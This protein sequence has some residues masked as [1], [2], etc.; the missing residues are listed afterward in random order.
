MGPDR[1][2]SITA[3]TTTHKQEM[4]IKIQNKKKHKY[5]NK[6]IN[7]GQARPQHIIANT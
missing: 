6:N 4:E 3:N 7:T 1:P 5:T 2:Q